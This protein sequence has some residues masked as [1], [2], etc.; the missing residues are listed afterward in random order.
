MRSLKIVRTHGNDKQTI[1]QLHVVEANRVL[2]TLATLELPW[3]NNKRGVSCIPTGEYTVRKRISPKFGLSFIIDD[4]LNRS[5][6]LLH[7]GNYHTQI[8]GCVLLGSHFKDINKDGYTDVVS[9]KKSL[10]KLLD[11]MP[12]EFSLTIT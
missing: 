8:K 4:V 9:S 3:S 1:G 5:Y 7:S 12:E 10:E 2:L 11:I 6:I